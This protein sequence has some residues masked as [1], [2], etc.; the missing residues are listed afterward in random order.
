MKQR[1]TFV[2]V[3][4][5]GTFCFAQTLDFKTVDFSATALLNKELTAFEFTTIATPLAFEF[6]QNDSKFS[7]LE[8]DTDFEFNSEIFNSKIFSNLNLFENNYQNDYNYSRGCDPLED[9]LTH[10]LNS[11]DVM[12]S[13]VVD[14]AVNGYLKSLIFND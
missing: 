14:Y 13:R 2:F 6:Q 4:V 5:L 9:G 8:A 3:F 12:I 7:M 11:S 1:I 10:T